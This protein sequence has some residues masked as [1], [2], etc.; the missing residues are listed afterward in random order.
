MDCK[1]VNMSKQPGKQRGKGQPKSPKQ[2]RSDFEKGSKGSRITT[3]NPTLAWESKDNDVSWYTKYPKLVEAQSSIIFNKIMGALYNYTD[4]V[5]STTG[6]LTVGHSDS[7]IPGVV[8]LIWRPFHCAKGTLVDA[9]NIASKNLYTFVRH[10]NSGH[11]NY[12][13]SDLMQYV[14]A[15]QMLYVQVEQLKRDLRMTLTFNAQNRYAYQA[16]LESFG[17][18]TAHIK[19]L[20]DNYATLVGA[21]NVVIAQLNTFKIPKDMNVLSRRLWMAH[22]VWKDD[23]LDKATYFAYFTDFYYHYDWANATL[24]G[25]IIA[26]GLNGPSSFSASNDFRN[27]LNAIQT[28]INNLLAQEDIGIMIGDILKAY[29]DENCFSTSLLGLDEVIDAEFSDEMANQFRNATVLTNTASYGLDTGSITIKQDAN[30]SQILYE[31]SGTSFYSGARNRGEYYFANNAFNPTGYHIGKYKP[32]LVVDSDNPTNADVILNTRL[33]VG[34]EYAFNSSSGPSNGFGKVT[35]CGTEIIITGHIVAFEMDQA[36]ISSVRYTPF[37]TVN[38]VETA[39]VS[40]EGDLLALCA[41]SQISFA[42]NRIYLFGYSTGTSSS[43]V[44]H[45][46][47][48]NFVK[49]KNVV[50]LDEEWLTNMHD[51]CQLSEYTIPMFKLLET[52]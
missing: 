50:V 7:A 38:L 32:A 47:I 9:I 40:V 1:E 30:D 31:E 48:Y 21:L 12:E 51:A 46:S 6:T 34:I 13:S 39:A 28:E 26:D 16:V 27:R 11:V 37:K 18:S 41:C 35:H 3:K 52:E 4:K 44:Y 22:N 10:A 45:G 25:R 8:R 42:P 20:K 5:K 29:K 36:G 2:N 24:E 15:V 14:M 49:G 23:S 33:S 43:P 19:D 17:Y